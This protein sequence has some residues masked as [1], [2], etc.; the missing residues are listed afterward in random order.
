M[1]AKYRVDPG[2][3][4]LQEL[5]ATDGLCLGSC[6]LRVR[7]RRWVNMLV[8]PIRFPEQGGV[9]WRVFLFVS[10]LL[11]GYGALLWEERSSKVA[12]VLHADR[13]A[14]LDLRIVTAG[15]EPAWKIT[16]FWAWP[17][18]RGRGL[19]VITAVLAAADAT[20]TTLLL[21]AA[22][23][24]LAAEYYASLG[25]VVRPGQEQAKRPWI[26][27][28]PGVVHAEAASITRADAA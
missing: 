5:A 14:G 19:D 2:D 11:G 18:G 1:N 17:T 16:S 9:G 22:N 25:F 20:G 27:R 10:C 21:N 3:G 26:E 7:L 8:T 24:R 15:D 6:G 12:A 4:F 13:H 28:L 23:R